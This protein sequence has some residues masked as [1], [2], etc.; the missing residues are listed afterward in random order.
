MIARSAP[1]PQPPPRR[2]SLRRWGGR[3]LRGLWLAALLDTAGFVWFAATL[4]APPPDIAERADG[5]V[6]LTGGALRVSTGLRL[7]AEGAGQRLLISGVHPEVVLAEILAQHPTLSPAEGPVEG[8]EN[9]VDLGYR[10]G[11]THG[12]AAETAHWLA[13]NRFSSIILVTASY[14]MPRAILEL[15]GRVGGVRIIPHPVHPAGFGGPGW[16]QRRENLIL[17][18]GE[19][20]KTLGAWLRLVVRGGM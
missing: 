6:V 20:H 13:L 1:S 4:P 11:D 8:L 17:V 2:R 18:G 19:Y 10:A 12:N 16:W 5:I 15:R 9:R 7:L 3:V 14:H